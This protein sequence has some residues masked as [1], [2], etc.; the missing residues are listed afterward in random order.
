MATHPCPV[1]EDWWGKLDGD[2]LDC[3]TAGA[4]SAEELGMRLGL[5]EHAAVSLLVALAR[6]GKVRISR[7]EL[8]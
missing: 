8:A 1:T 6:D 3:L 7:V 4:M 2:L 5:S